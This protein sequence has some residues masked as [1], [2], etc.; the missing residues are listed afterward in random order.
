MQLDGVVEYLD[1]V[2]GM[3]DLAV[4]EVVDHAQQVV[5]LVVVVEVQARVRGLDGVRLDLL[6]QVGRIH[7]EQIVEEPQEEYNETFMLLVDD[8]KYERI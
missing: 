6:L 5:D 3:Y 4:A 1:R 2:L 7:R 8:V